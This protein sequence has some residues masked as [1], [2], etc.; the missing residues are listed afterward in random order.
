MNVAWVVAVA[1]G[2]LAAVGEDTAMAVAAA[3]FALVAFV[4]S[5]LDD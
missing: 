2:F 4:A 1:F 5:C 3:A